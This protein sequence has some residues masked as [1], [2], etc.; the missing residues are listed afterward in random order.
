[1]KSNSR[2]IILP[3]LAVLGFVLGKHFDN[4]LV[5]YLVF[6]LLPILLIWFVLKYKRPIKK[7]QRILLASFISFGLAF[8]MFIIISIV[9]NLYPILLSKYRIFFG[10]GEFIPFVVGT[11]LL[12]VNRILFYEDNNLL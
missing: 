11:I 3:I 4:N 6:T 9:Q 12:I 5:N 2:K 8:Y 7:Q 10:I 1:M